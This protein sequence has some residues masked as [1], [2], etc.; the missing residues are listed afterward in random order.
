MLVTYQVGGDCVTYS[1]TTD[2]GVGNVADTRLQRQQVL[3]KTAMLNLVLEELNQV[4]GN[5]AGGVILG[6]IGLGLIGVV[7]LDNGDD[8]F[9]VNGH[10]GSTDTVL[11]SHDKVGLAIGREIGH[12]DIVKTLEGRSG[13][14]DL[15]DDLVGHLDELGGGADGGTADD[16]TI[17]G[18]SGGFNDSDVQLVVGLVLGVVAW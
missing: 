12:G 14:V 6:R 5:S 4:V 8:L 11:G 13:R 9:R 18:D 7:G 17:L 3:G 10:M 2:D 1:K 16:A 15:D